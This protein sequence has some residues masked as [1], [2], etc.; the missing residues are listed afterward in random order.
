[1]NLYNV[2]LSQAEHFTF[3][4]EA[5]TPEEAKEMALERFRESDDGDSDSELQDTAVISIEI[6][7]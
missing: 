3:N 5:D 6:K 7:E 2:V 4:I 1:M